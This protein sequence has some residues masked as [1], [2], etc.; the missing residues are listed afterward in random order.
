[1]AKIVSV[2]NEQSST[3]VLQYH[4]VIL[5]S[6]TIYMEKWKI[7]RST[8]MDKSVIEKILQRTKSVHNNIQTRKMDGAG[9]GLF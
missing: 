8:K 4:T 5:R 1:M 2:Q 7:A 3:P 6:Y 9:G